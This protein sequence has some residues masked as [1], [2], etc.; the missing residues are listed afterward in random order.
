MKGRKKAGIVLLVL[1]AIV[2]ALSLTVD[3]IGIGG[4]PVFGYRQVIGTVGG[5]IAVV[6]G[7]VLALRR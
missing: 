1:G 7:L 3:L 5:A 4:S 2:L 6:A